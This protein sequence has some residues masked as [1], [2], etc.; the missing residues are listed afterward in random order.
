MN[1]QFSSVTQS[2]PALCDP[3]DCST[4]GLPVHYQLLEFTQTQSTESVTPSNHLSLC[5]PLLLLPSIFPRI[6]VF[7][8]ETVLCIRWPKYW[9]FSFSISPSSEYSGLVSFRM[10]WLDLLAVQGTQESSPTLQFKSINSLALSFLYS[11]TLTSI[12]DHWKN[13]SL[14]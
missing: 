13:H 14:D 9:R 4:P 1:I 8:N 6:R 7:S 10:G 3:M 11:P 5:R 2:C 12:H